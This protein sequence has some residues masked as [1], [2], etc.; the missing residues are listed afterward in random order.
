MSSAAHRLLCPVRGGSLGTGGTEPGD[1][2]EVEARAV[3]TSVNIS[4]TA[5]PLVARGKMRTEQG[6]PLAP[7]PLP[8]NWSPRWSPLYIFSGARQNPNCVPCEAGSGSE[9]GHG[10]PLGTP[11]CCSCCSLHPP[12]SDTGQPSHLGGLIQLLQPAGGGVPRQIFSR[13]S[14]RRAPGCLMAVWKYLGS[15][16]TVPG[17]SDVSAL[18]FPPTQGVCTSELSQRQLSSFR[19]GCR[20]P[21]GRQGLPVRTARLWCRKPRQ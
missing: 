21:S 2:G 13:P 7:R 3:N 20:A 9:I 15:R 5:W 10:I 11:A 16:D 18:K 19:P 8:S 14:H 1:A 12:L 4:R 17:T 6:H